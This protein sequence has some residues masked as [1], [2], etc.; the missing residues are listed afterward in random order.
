M[1]LDLNQGLVAYEAVTLP[2]SYTC[3]VPTRGL[4]PPIHSLQGSCLTIGLHRHV[5][6]LCGNLAI[7]STEYSAHTLYGNLI[8]GTPPRIRTETVRI[9]SAMP[10]ASWASGA[11]MLRTAGVEPATK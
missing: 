3:M 6:A 8:F 4:E 9:L 7:Y 2:L 5:V 10:T 11:F 1:S